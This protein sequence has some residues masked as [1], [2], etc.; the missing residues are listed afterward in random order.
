MAVFKTIIGCYVLSDLACYICLIIAVLV[1]FTTNLSKGPSHVIF[2]VHRSERWYPLLHMR[3]AP[4]HIYAP[5]LLGRSAKFH[6]TGEG[7]SQTST[8]IFLFY[9]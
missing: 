7:D 5:A 4:V 6:R 2:W 9:P 3:S 1:F 8:F